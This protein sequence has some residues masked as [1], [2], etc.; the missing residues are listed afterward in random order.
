MQIE[1]GKH[2]LIP[3][4]KAATCIVKAYVKFAEDLQYIFTTT[5]SAADLDSICCKRIFLEDFSLTVG[6]QV[7]QLHSHDLHLHICLN[8]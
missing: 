5:H 7:I 3:K 8:D 4:S 2:S 6:I 1:P